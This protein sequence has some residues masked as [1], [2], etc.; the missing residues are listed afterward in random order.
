SWRT[1]VQAIIQRHM[2]A[3]G[4]QLDIQNYPGEEIFNHLLP[5]GQASPPTGAVAGRYDIAEYETAPGN[6][7]PDDSGLLSCD[8]I[9]PKGY[10]WTFYCNPAL[11]KLFTQEQ[12]TA[13]AGV[14]QQLFVQIH[15]I[16]LRELP[17]ITLYSPI[18]F[19]LVRKGTHNYLPGPY[20]D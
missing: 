2:R 9:P 19:A 1:N 17:F 11:D 12:A 14:R 15:R 10:N 18:L 3:I 13:D 4:I 6:Y 16:Y 5:G 7:D 8:Q 20:C